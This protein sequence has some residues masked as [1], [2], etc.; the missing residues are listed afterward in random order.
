MQSMSPTHTTSCWGRFGNHH[1]DSAFLRDLPFGWAGVRR[2]VQLKAKAKNSQ[3]PGQATGPMVGSVDCPSSSQ[4]VC[5]IFWCSSP[6]LGQP[7]RSCAAADT[8][9][10]TPGRAGWV[11]SCPGS[12][13]FAAVHHGL[14]RKVHTCLCRGSPNPACFAPPRFPVDHGEA[15]R[16]KAGR[17]RGTPAKASVDFSRQSLV[18]ECPGNRALF[19]TS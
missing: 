10:L 16:G 6:W 14:S 13:G 17:I 15:G 8:N 3:V 19:R 18:K 1:S 7:R 5:I 2:S 11:R 4:W 12:G 9:P